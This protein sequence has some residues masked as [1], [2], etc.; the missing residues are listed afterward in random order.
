MYLYYFVWVCAE[1]FNKTVT[2]F[3]ELMKELSY[4]LKFNAG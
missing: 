4:K 2:S 3:S 1:T